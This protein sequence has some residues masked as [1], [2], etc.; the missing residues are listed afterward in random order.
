MEPVAGPVVEAL[1]Q[2]VAGRGAGARGAGGTVTRGG[3][4]NGGAGLAV[5]EALVVV[6]LVAVLRTRGRVVLISRLSRRVRQFCARGSARAGGGS[7]EET[8][9]K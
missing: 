8:G 1:V 4:G 2:P 9:L 6:A 5:V 3:G 7:G